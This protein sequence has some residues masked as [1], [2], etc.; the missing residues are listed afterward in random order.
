MATYARSSLFEQPAAAAAANQL[1]CRTNRT[2]R[3]RPEG[4]G[5]ARHSAP[6]YL[7]SNVRRSSP[8][9]ESQVTPLVAA[10]QSGNGSRRNFAP[11]SSAQLP[12]VAAASRDSSTRSGGGGGRDESAGA[13]IPPRSTEKWSP[14]PPAEPWGALAAPVTG[15]TAGLTPTRLPGR[16]APSQGTAFSAPEPG[17]IAPTSSRDPRMYFD[18]HTHAEQRRQDEG[19]KVSIV[20]FSHLGIERRRYPRCR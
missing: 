15:L 2:H 8:R 14:P 20:L 3:A 16:L 4:R 13:S 12:G 17:I 6:C 19:A 10:R 1:A 7:S 9:G 11:L 18:A 5:S